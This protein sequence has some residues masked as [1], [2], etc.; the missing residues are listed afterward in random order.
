MTDPSS[1]LISPHELSVRHLFAVEP[2]ELLFHYTTIGGAFGILTS[3]ALWMTKIRYLN[4]TSELEIGIV[5]F[6]DIL[7]ELL[8][9]HGPDDEHRLLESVR[10]GL[11]SVAASNICVSSFCEH[12]DLLSQWRWYGEGGR[13]VSIG[14]SSRVL[15]GM[16]KHAINLWKCIY[17]A[18]A[19]REL[20]LAFVD[21]LLESYRSE[22]AARGGG[23]LDAESSHYLLRGFFASFLQIAPIIKNPNFAEE[24]EWRLV[25]LPV[26]V[27]DEA[28]GVS[29]T[30]DRIIQRYELRFPRDADGTCRAIARVVV[31]PTKDPE[32]IGEAIA[33]LCR[34]RKIAYDT[35]EYS[36]IPFRHR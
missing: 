18:A 35:I 8:E 32:L 22:K 36:R 6:R 2:P 1:L 9:A 25:T 19:H 14:V 13:G 29:M 27:D 3:D 15:S 24:R 7:N 20:L 5:T 17:D 28:Y 26:D 31:A 10:D 30:G 16:G 34:K 21:R 33:L 23:E 12:G 4:D 11:D